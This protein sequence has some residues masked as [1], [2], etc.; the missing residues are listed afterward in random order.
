MPGKAG[1]LSVRLHRAPVHEGGRRA[2]PA[3][4]T[5]LAAVV[6]VQE[7]GRLRCS[8]ADLEFDQEVTLEVRARLGQCVLESQICFLRPA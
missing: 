1:R 4:S 6:E 8:S 7:Y 3:E 5:Q 2:A